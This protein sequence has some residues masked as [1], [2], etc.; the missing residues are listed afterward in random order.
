LHVGTNLGHV[1]TFKILP[2]A[3]GRHGV[4]FAGT[5]S[6]E[7][8]VIRVVPI[9]ADTGHP[10]SASQQTVANLRNGLKV[11]GVLVAIAET[12]VRI[13][14][15]ASNKGASKTWDQSACLS[16]SV[17]RF[18]DRGYA[19]VGLFIDG[20]A[21]AFSIPNLKE[22]GVSKLSLVMD[23]TRFRDAIITGSGDILGWTGPSEVALMNV[24]GTGLVM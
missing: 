13:F 1:A 5:V 15:P 4:H 17:S 6:L 2:E 22:I 14:K 9:N 3:G 12:G 11:N 24:W 16:A 23:P 21:R 7:S 10:A 8:P 19:L 20:T 18:E